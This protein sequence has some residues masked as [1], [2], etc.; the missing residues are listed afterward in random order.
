[1]LPA[2]PLV[3]HWLLHGFA[4]AIAVLHLAFVPVVLYRRSEP[5][6]TIAW[7]LCL[8]LLP[9]AGVILY[10]IF[11]RGEVRRSARARRALLA[12]RQR[13]EPEPDYECVAPHLR[14][15]AHAAW[16]AGRTAL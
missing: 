10:W 1:M 14:P 3:W 16:E 2:L 7:L 11:G 6:V 9:A 8:L 12:E 15:L 4:L 5:S 13:A